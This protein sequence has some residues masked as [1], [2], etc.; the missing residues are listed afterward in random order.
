ME[1]E[2]EMHLNVGNYFQFFKFRKTPPWVLL[3]SLQEY[4]TDRQDGWDELPNFSS[5]KSFL[6]Y[7]SLLILS[8][9]EQLI[10]LAVYYRV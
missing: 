8:D 5:D 3:N 1:L 7:N 10:S 9:V 6:Q 4:N 2:N